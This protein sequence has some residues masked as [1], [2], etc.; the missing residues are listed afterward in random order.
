MD[1]LNVSYYTS[2]PRILQFSLQPP[3]SH[4]IVNISECCG[5]K[6]FC[7]DEH[8]LDS[9][10]LTALDRRAHQTVTGSIVNVVNRQTAALTV[11]NEN[12]LPC[13]QCMC[14][15]AN[16]CQFKGHSV[17]IAR[18]LHI[19]NLDGIFVF[20]D[21]LADIIVR[22]RRLSRSSRRCRRGCLSRCRCRCL[23]RCRRGSLG[24]RLSR[25]FSGCSGRFYCRRLSGLFSRCSGRFYCRY[26]GRLFRRRLGRLFRRRLGR[27]FRRC[28]SRCCS[29]CLGRRIR[30]CCSGCLGGGCSGFRRSSGRIR[31]CRLLRLL[32]TT[33]QNRGGDH[34]RHRSGQNPEKYRFH[35]HYILSLELGLLLTVC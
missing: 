5:C 9:Q 17:L 24:G 30:R 32:C 16:I 27:L 2:F 4:N 35:F 1:L 14:A 23:S 26:L 19:Q 20:S 28:L 33:T 11:Y 3:K 34:K 21:L 8:C 29:R 7:Q 15:F 10:R 6:A 31:R 22:C 13:G 18:L 25:L 12:T